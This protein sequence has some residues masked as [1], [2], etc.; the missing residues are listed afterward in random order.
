MARPPIK[1]TTLHNHTIEEL[2]QIRNSHPNKRATQ[3]LN[4]IILNYEGSSSSEIAAFL[5]TSIPTIISYVNSWNKHGSLILED[6]RG[7]NCNN[8]KLSAEMVDDLLYVVSNKLPNEYG[9]LGNIWTTPLLAKYIY[10]TYEVECSDETIRRT[11]HKNK[12]SF[13]RAQKK[14]S[15][16]KPVEQEMFKKN[17]R[18]SAFCRRFF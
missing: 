12:Y 1:V 9:F 18:N 3:I 4:T 5:A 8:A 7:K 16:A 15:K 11:L 10:M 17:A 6:K 14:P 2:K 13:K